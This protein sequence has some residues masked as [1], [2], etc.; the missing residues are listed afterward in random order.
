MKLFRNLGKGKFKDVSAPSRATCPSS[1]PGRPA[2]PGATS[3]TTAVL[4]L[5]VGCLRGP[6]RFFRGK[7]DGAFEDASEASG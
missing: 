3:T 7:G 5:F 6:N 2:P 4:D 1:R